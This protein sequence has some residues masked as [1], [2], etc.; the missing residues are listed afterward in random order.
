[1]L[2]RWIAP[3]LASLIVLSP[4]AFAQD[5]GSNAYID[6]YFGDWRASTPHATHG[7]LEERDILT[8]GDALKPAKKG[9]VLRYINSYSYATLAPHTSTASTRLD[10][11]QEIFY[12]LS[13]HGTAAAGGDTAEIY[14][15]VAILMP[16]KLE[17]TISNAGDQ[18]LTMYLISEPTPAGFRPNPT[19]LIRDENKIPIASTDGLWDHIVKTLYVTSDGL[20]TLQSVLT[21]VLDPLTVG[22][23]HV[24]NHTDIEEVWTGIDGTSLALV[25]P[26]LRRQGPGI[27]YM[28]PPDNLA[29][30]TNINSSEDGQVKLLYFARYHPHDARP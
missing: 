7:S 20:G 19:M 2:N 28:H 27:A 3:A 24:T 16:E 6:M 18:P 23:P 17:F 8:R 21:V 26:F 4:L 11:K 25:G 22:K 14:R 1:M 5:V 29:P 12:F 30:H 9:A 10:G 15:N 13:G